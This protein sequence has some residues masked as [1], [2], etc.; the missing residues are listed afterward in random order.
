MYGTEYGSKEI[1]QRIEIRKNSNVVSHDADIFTSIHKNV[2]WYKIC[3]SMYIIS[4]KSTKR[5]RKNPLLVL[6]Q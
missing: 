4:A 3:G 1:E 5:Y 6:Y 2:N